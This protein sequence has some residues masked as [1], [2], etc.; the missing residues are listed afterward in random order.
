MLLPLKE[1][2]KCQ[3]NGRFQA[4]CVCVCVGGW[5]GGGGGHTTQ[6]EAENLSGKVSSSRGTG[7]DFTFEC[8][9]E[10]K[11]RC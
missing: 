6:S 5:G 3:E 9:T 1:A 4:W 7:S 10:P 8:M 2:S 11:P